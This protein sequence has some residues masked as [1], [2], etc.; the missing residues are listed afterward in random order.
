MNTVTLGRVTDPSHRL[1]RWTVRRMFKAVVVGAVLLVALSVG[2]AVVHAKSR[3]DCAHTPPPDTVGKPLDQVRA[4]LAHR[5]GTTLRDVPQ[6]S[7][8]QGSGR[9]EL[10]VL[11]ARGSGAHDAVIVQ[12]AR[13]PSGRG[14]L[15]TTN[16]CGK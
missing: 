5:F 15:I 14:W 10:A 4:V 3:S 6:I 7:P 13:A 16:T 1:P 8:D 12:V 2:V 9:I 11:N